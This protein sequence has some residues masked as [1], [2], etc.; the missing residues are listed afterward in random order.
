LEK[1]A[2]FQLY[3]TVFFLKTFMARRKVI[4][5]RVRGHVLEQ[6]LQYGLLKPLDIPDECWTQ[7]NLDF[8]TKLLVPVTTQGHD[9]IITFIDGNTKGV[10]WVAALTAEKF[11]DLFVNF[12]VRLHGL[13]DNIISDR[14]SRFNSRF[15]KHLTQLWEIKPAFST[16]FHPQ[17]DG[18]AEKSNPITKRFQR[19]F[20]EIPARLG[21]LASYTR[22]WL[23]F[24]LP[25]IYW[26]ISF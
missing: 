4:L 22:I 16:A 1:S 11:P 15:W 6:N 13:P 10:H 21:Y 3:Q 12:Y 25:S 23:Q 18:K 2:R 20:Q 8:I 17:T 26:D 14:D 7:I 19:A 24:P 5:P 9:T